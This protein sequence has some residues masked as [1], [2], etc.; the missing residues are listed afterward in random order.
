[1]A[2]NITRGFFSDEVVGFVAISGQ[3]SKG[4]HVPFSETKSFLI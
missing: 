2:N 3:T 4:M 1:M